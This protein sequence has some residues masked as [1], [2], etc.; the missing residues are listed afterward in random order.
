MLI[1]KN[2]VFHTVTVL[3]PQVMEVHLSF[4]LVQSLTWRLLVVAVHVCVRTSPL[5]SARFELY[6]GFP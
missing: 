5:E 1:K 3:N 2:A 6:E 4:S